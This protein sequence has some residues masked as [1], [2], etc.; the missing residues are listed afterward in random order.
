MEPKNEYP[1]FLCFFTIFYPGAGMMSP[2][3]KIYKIIQHYQDDSK[4]NISI[5]WVF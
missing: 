3:N 1:I 2:I 5:F 4:L